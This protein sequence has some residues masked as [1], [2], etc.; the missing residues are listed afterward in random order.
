MNLF[1]LNHS[2]SNEKKELIEM[3]IFINKIFKKLIKLNLLK[4]YRKNIM[5]FINFYY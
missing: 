3:E 5:I 4:K 1:I 2:K